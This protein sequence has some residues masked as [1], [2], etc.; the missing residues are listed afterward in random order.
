MSQTPP[1][2]Q[3]FLRVFEPLSRTLENP[4]ALG[5]LALAAFFIVRSIVMSASK[6]PEPFSMKKVPVANTPAQRDFTPSEL[7]AFDG[8]DEGTALYI[9]V[10]GTV[11]DVSKGRGFYGPGGPYANFAG[12][13][14]SRGLALS[15]FGAELLADIN[16][17]IDTLADLEPSEQ[18]SLD[19]WAGF[20]AGK[21]VAVG[22]LVNAPGVEATDGAGPEKSEA[23]D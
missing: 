6:S 9:A 4:V 7:A 2:Q 22:R 23:S 5:F 19:E 18:D 21:Y 13:D 8:R 11:Y 12:R 1:G 10:K 17:P 3:S 16:G 15:S 20:F 14:A